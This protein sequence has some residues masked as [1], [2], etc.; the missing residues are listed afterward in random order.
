MPDFARA[1]AI[2]TAGA[3]NQE[4]IRRSIHCFLMFGGKSGA[5]WF[6]YC[7]KMACF[8]SLV[9]PLVLLWFRIITKLVKSFG[10]ISWPRFSAI[11]D[12]GT[13]PPSFLFTPSKTG[14]LLINPCSSKLTVHQRA[15]PHRHSPQDTCDRGPKTGESSGKLA[16]N[17]QRL[18]FLSRQAAFLHCIPDV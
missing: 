14:T 18:S 15:I 12:R 7:F 6:V 2:C 1:L 3:L 13:I 4:S 11:S 5:E 16:G 8:I 9:S 17:L 10:E